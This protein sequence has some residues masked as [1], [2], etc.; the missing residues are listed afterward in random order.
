MYLLASHNHSISSPSCADWYPFVGSS[1]TH[2]CARGIGI[3]KVTII[4]PACF[5]SAPTEKTVEGMWETTQRGMSSQCPEGMHNST[6]EDQSELLCNM[7][8]NIKVTLSKWI[9]QSYIRISL[10]KA[11]SSNNSIVVPNNPWTWVI[12]I[13]PN[14]PIRKCRLHLIKRSKKSHRGRSETKYSVPSPII[15]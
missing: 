1:S 14:L 4:R 2:A 5:V 8:Y 11:V 6:S 13:I 15:F 9:E 7:A 3:H 12:I 10:Y